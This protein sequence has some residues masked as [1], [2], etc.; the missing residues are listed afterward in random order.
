MRRFCLALLVLTLTA[1]S[2]SAQMGRRPRDYATNDPDIWVSAGIG[3]FR[4]NAVNDGVTG[5]TWNFGNATNIQY[6]GPHE[7]G[8]DTGTSL[9][10]PGRWARGGVPM[11]RR[12]ECCRLGGRGPGHGNND[13]QRRQPPVPYTSDHAAR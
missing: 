5:S 6:L 12:N 7:K 13:G 4:A 2:L 9:V 11:G 1:G 8:T 3:G 10:I